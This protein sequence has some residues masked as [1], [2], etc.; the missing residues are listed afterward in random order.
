MTRRLTKETRLDEDSLR[1]IEDEEVDIVVNEG[2]FR[3]VV[4]LV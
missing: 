3:S 2:G 4:V 1:E